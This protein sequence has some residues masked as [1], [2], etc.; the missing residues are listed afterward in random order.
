MA[1]GAT[2][3]TTITG[4]AAELVTAIQSSGITTSSTYNVTVND[5][6]SVSDANTIDADT[7]GTVTATISDGDLST[8][9]GLTGT[10]NAYTITVTDTTV[11]AADLNTLDGKVFGVLN[12]ALAVSLSGSDDDI[13]QLINSIES[14]T[15]STYDVY[16]DGE[17]VA[18]S[19]AFL[20]AID[21]D[22][23][24][25][26]FV[27]NNDGLIGLAADINSV[28]ASNFIYFV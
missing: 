8:L 11:A 19:A 18:V 14:L 24:G 12:V 17:G 27:S 23:A 25:S 6:V 9:G 10:G 4:T 28:M 16:I 3:A 26:I 15:S 20:R 1:V 22:T 5:A 13:Y 7:T 2:A 21:E